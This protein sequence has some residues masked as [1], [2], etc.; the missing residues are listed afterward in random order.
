MEKS[1]DE[2]LAGLPVL[3]RRGTAVISGVAHDSRRVK[4]GDL[5]VAIRGLRQDGHQF[6]PEAIGRGA[7][8][9]LVERPVEV[10]AGVAVARVADTRAALGPVAASFYGYPAEKLLVVGVTGTNGKTTTTYLI[11]AILEEAGHIVGLIGTV[12]NLIGERELPAERTTP[13]ASDLQELLARM[14]AEG[15]TAAVL[16]VS[17]HAVVL[18]RIDGCFF[19]AGVFTNLTQDHLDFHGTLQ[20]YL[21]AKAAFLA[22]LGRGRR[23][24]GRKERAVAAL[25]ADD[26]QASFIRRQIDEK[27]VRIVTYG[28]RE[29]AEVQGAEV[30]LE[31][32][33]MAM[34]VLLPTGT[35]PLRLHLTGEFNVSNALAAAAVTWGL[36]IP[37]EAIQKGLAK[38]RG[39]PGRFEAV[40]EGQNFS[41]IVDYAHT[42]DGLEKILRAVRGV[43]SG[44]VIAVFGCGGDRD[45]TKRPV[46]GEIAGREADY[47][48][49]TSD[50]PRSEDPAAICREIEEGLRP[51][52]RPY[53]VVLDRAQAIQR[54][55]D[56][57]QTGDAVVI[58][59]KGHETYQ[60]FRDRTVHFDDREEARRAL[61]RRLAREGS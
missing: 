52:A 44:R 1:L 10:P 21:E 58:A 35:L 27:K 56:L 22:G 31:A 45:R 38:V 37:P 14:V 61:R 16:E 54:A 15:A 42:P 11:K 39:V 3:E 25:N 34:R 9:V 7:A 8:A 43:T 32:R 19:D 53:E 47:V 40:E 20:A 24:G 36:G 57:A 41:V 30:D 12:R 48:V 33:G 55:V 49:V 2:V 17:S 59:G 26:P 46:M 6:I 23:F 13:E 18:H 29:G 5:F 50:N 60:I 28:R 51:T 4:G